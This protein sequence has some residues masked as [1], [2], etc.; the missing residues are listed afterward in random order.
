MALPLFEATTENGIR[1]ITVV[2]DVEQTDGDPYARFVAASLWTMFLLTERDYVAEGRP[3]I[4]NKSTVIG[5][6][7]KRP[8]AVAS[9]D[10]TI[11][12]RIANQ[13]EHKVEPAN[14]NSSAEKILNLVLTYTDPE[15][16]GQ[17]YLEET[18]RLLSRWWRAKR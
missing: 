16:I 14:E 17:G 2:L 12:E 15:P 6:G 11:I 8:L 1:M 4:K 5:G 7:K 9:K 10:F 18:K 13:A 3:T